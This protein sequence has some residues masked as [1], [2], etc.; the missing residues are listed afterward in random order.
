MT[1]S[2]I[3]PRSGQPFPESAP[4]D[5]FT[6][7]S[8]A[9]PMVF[10]FGDPEPVLDNSLTDYLG[11]FADIGGEYWRPPVS[12]E[13]LEKLTRANAYHG[14]ILAFKRNMTAKWFQPHPY[15]SYQDL[16]AAAYDWHVFGMC[17][18]QKVFNRLGGLLRFRRLP[19]L[20]M[21][22]MLEPDRFLQLQ[23]TWSDPGAGREPIRYKPGEVI[24]LKETDLR[25]TVYGLPDYLGGLHSVL[26]SEA[27]TIFR[28]RYYV[29]G[30]QMGYI[31]VT[32]GAGIGEETADAL[33]KKIKESK[34]PG[35]FRSL[36]L[37]LPN[38]ANGVREPVKIIPVGDIQTK[39]DYQAVSNISARQSLAMHR[40]QPGI[41]GVMPDNL[42]G[43]GDLRKVMEVYV[44]LEVDAMQAPFLELNDYLPMGAPRIGFDEPAWERAVGA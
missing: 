14:P 33:E 24:Q 28:R 18:F 31:F 43:F 29:N 35:N 11:I 5:T 25:Q 17:Y 7:P 22:R 21:R 15:L 12:L 27:S 38:P 37:N 32:Q 4:R 16:R 10:S 6:V 8:D 40:M 1:S 3:D 23:S 36:Y 41:A 44:E 2:L 20:V 42:T 19:A 13:G 30:A 9:G 34:G 39:D 26:L